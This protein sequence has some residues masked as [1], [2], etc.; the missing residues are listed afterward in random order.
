MAPLH[1]EAFNPARKEWVRVGD[2]YSTD[3]PGTMSNNKPDGSRELYQFA[4]AKDDS[5]STIYRSGLGVDIE[6]G[7]F[8]GAIIDPL[9]LEVVKELKREES[10]EMDIKTD[11][12][13]V[14]TKIRF[15]H[16]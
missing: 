16:T 6:I 9:K 4:C 12:N 10:F 11:R 1:I 2:V 8:R 14:V 5:K 13:P 7:R 3:P 15:T